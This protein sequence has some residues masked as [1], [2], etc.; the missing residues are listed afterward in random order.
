MADQEVQVISPSVQH[1]G[2]VN[3]ASSLNIHG[4]VQTNAADVIQLSGAPPLILTLR[5]DVLRPRGI[6]QSSEENDTAGESHHPDLLTKLVQDAEPKAPTSTMAWF[7]SHGSGSIQ[8]ASSKRKSTPVPGNDTHY[9]NLSLIHA[10]NGLISTLLACD[11]GGGKDRSQVRDCDDIMAPFNDMSFPWSSALNLPLGEDT[12]CGAC[13]VQIQ[14][15]KDD[16]FRY[17]SKQHRSVH[18]MWGAEHPSRA[19]NTTGLINPNDIDLVDASSSVSNPSSS[20][21]SRVVPDALYCG[22]GHL[23]CML[24][25]GMSWISY[26]S[27]ADSN[28]GRFARL[29]CPIDNCHCAFS[30]KKFWRT[31]YSPSVYRLL[32]DDYT[33]RGLLHEFQW[34]YLVWFPITCNTKLHW[35]RVRNHPESLCW[36]PMGISPFECIPGRLTTAEWIWRRSGCEEMDA[37]TSAGQARSLC[38]GVSSAISTDAKSVVRMCDSDGN[39]RVHSRVSLACMS[40]MNWVEESCR[41]IFIDDASGETLPIDEFMW[42]SQVSVSSIPVDASFTSALSSLHGSAPST[43]TR[44]GLEVLP[45]GDL[46]DDTS[47]SLFRTL[48]WLAHHPCPICG[49]CAV[50]IRECDLDEANAT[51][52]CVSCHTTWCKICRRQVREDDKHGAHWNN[53]L[54]SAQCASNHGA[55]DSFVAHFLARIGAF[56]STEAQQ[57]ALEQCIQKVANWMSS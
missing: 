15:S 36:R 1:H 27:R 43:R 2:N 42:E 45:H 33:Q 26:A 51:T 30:M 35:D 7:V 41:L 37:A 22:N 8:S 16:V 13:G 11:G 28:D 17:T 48:T 29:G 24:C 9:S 55:D 47:K 18:P 52:R 25:L 19:F 4:A 12:R 38:F 39:A 14:S 23:T 10:P 49:Y 34:F 53:F 5:D 20:S 56:F 54:S 32:R 6:L 31:L 57:V 46:S 21:S 40:L 44:Y 50:S 3:L